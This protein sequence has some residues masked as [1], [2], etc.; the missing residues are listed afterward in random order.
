MKKLITLIA[1][2]TLLVSCE[3]PTNK[4]KSTGHTYG[5]DDRSGEIQIMTY[6][7]C[8]Y[9]GSFRQSNTDWGTHKG[10]CSNPIHK[11]NVV[12]VYDTV[13]VPIIKII[14]K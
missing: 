13:V 14:R 10:D 11:E 4:A 3:A 1:I 2:T 5:T 9:I 6:D 12:T 7:G 8:E